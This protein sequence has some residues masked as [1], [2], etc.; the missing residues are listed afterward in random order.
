MDKETAVNLA[1]KLTKPLIE[2]KNLQLNA[3]VKGTPGKILEV[4]ESL[5]KGILEIEKKI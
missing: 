5:A 1:V 3:D 2:T 4:I